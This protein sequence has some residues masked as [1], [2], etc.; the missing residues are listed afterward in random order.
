LRLGRAFTARDDKAA[1]KVAIINEAAAR[2]LFPEGNP[3]G[4]RAGFSPEQNVE[5]EIVGVVRDTKYSSIR[6]APP[7][8]FYQH[9]RQGTTR[10][11]TFLLR[12]AGDPRALV[13]PA[14]TAVRQVD[15]TL[16]ITN[17]ATQ[18][19]Q[20]ER[21][22]AQ[23]RLFATAY[24]LFGGLSLILA[25]IGLFGLQSYNVARRTNEIGIRM[26]LGAQRGDVV[27]M[28]LRESL[29][30]VG[31][32]VVLGVGAALGAGSLV[33]STLY[34]LSPT[35][36]LTL[37]LAIALIL[38]VSTLAGYLPARR[39]ARVDPMIALQHR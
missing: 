33:S 2:E 28:V 7:P 23:E 9:Y 20:V 39:A 14:R 34:G 29:I 27:R 32:G 5:F 22:F 30:L 35:D 13:E 37:T 11:L 17:I 36:A 24:A 3:I 8:T 38:A 26:A 31:I 19:E 18:T 1:P 25:A 6:D 10:Q 4:K 12:T 15:G 16:P 21:R